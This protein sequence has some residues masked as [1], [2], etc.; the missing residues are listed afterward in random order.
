VRHRSGRF[1]VDRLTPP[2]V[3][4]ARGSRVAFQPLTGQPVVAIPFLVGP[5]VAV[6]AAVGPPGAR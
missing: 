2:T 4:A 1:D 6:G 3:T 5:M